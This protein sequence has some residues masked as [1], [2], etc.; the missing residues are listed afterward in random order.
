MPNKCCL[1]TVKLFIP[2][3]KQGTMVEQVDYES[4]FDSFVSSKLIEFGK[5]YSC[6]NS[7]ISNNHSVLNVAMPDVAYG[8]ITVKYQAE[9]S[10]LIIINIRCHINSIHSNFR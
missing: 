10:F 1:F 5:I 9:F 8:L 2:I 6:S 7:N 3:F 4:F